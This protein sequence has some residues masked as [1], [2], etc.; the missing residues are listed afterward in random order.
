MRRRSSLVERRCPRSSAESVL[1]EMDEA[2]NRLNRLVDGLNCYM[3]IDYLCR[4][5]T[6]RVTEP[7]VRHVTEQLFQSPYVGV[8]VDFESTT[9]AY[10]CRARLDPHVLNELDI[11]LASGTPNKTWR[12]FAVLVQLHIRAANGDVLASFS[13]PQYNVRHTN[14]WLRQDGSS[15]RFHVYVSQG[16]VEFILAPC[17]MNNTVVYLDDEVCRSAGMVYEKYYVNR[18]DSTV[19]RLYSVK[20]IMRVKWNFDQI[21]QTST[22]NIYSYARTQQFFVRRFLNQN[23]ERRKLQGDILSYYVHT[24]RD[25]TVAERAY[26]K[27]TFT[28]EALPLLT[29]IRHRFSSVLDIYSAGVSTSSVSEQSRGVYMR[30]V[31][32]RGHEVDAF[33]YTCNSD[34]YLD[35]IR[36]LTMLALIRALVVPGCAPQGGFVT[37]ARRVN[38]LATQALVGITLEVKGML[39]GATFVM[40]DGSCCQINELDQQFTESWE[41]SGKT[42]SGPSFDQAKWANALKRALGQ[43]L[44]GAEIEA[45][46]D[47]YKRRFIDEMAI[48]CG[49]PVPDASLPPAD[50]CSAVTEPLLVQWNMFIST[51]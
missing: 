8:D 22:S 49:I 12:G 31:A 40:G 13:D 45:Q 29:S 14:D 9:L 4:H 2:A 33:V 21:L 48:C 51:N 5:A 27:A 17:R 34:F 26:Q 15:L 7:V 11:Y 43:T 28:A 25:D 6:G 20:K 32:S 41:A 23:V 18:P 35:Q 1:A 36:A 3:C 37:F 30:T 46:I 16:D 10:A 47:I 19:V 39:E 44:L 24:V 42:A 50:A 38:M